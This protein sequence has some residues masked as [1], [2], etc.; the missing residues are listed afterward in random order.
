[1]F[2][3][4][5]IYESMT[6]IV[7]RMFRVPVNRKPIAILELTGHPTDIVNAVVSVL[8][9]MTFDFALWSKGQVPVTLV[10]EEAHRPCLHC[11]C[12]MTADMGSGLLEFL[13]ELG[14]REAIAFGDG[15]TLPVRIT[16]DELPAHAM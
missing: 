9:R 8:A 16:F 5:S 6:Q 14:L 3:S 13:S 11:A 1:M 2:G 7:G 15:V 12:R 4:L 10:C